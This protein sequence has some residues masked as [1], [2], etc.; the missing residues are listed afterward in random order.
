MNFAMTTYSLLLGL[1]G[2]SA[3]YAPADLAVGIVL[4]LDG[5]AKSV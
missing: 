4:W 3:T 1:A 5:L 2:G